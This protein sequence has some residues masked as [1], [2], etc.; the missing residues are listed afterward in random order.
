MNDLHFFQGQNLTLGRVEA[1]TGVVS[2]SAMPAGHVLPGL[3]AKQL[4]SSSLIL[5]EK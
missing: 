3:N 2:L 4:F 1:E 5:R